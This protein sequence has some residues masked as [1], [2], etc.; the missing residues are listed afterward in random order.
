MKKSAASCKG[1]GI[2]ASEQRLAFRTPVI[3]N[4]GER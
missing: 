3:L 1:G 4:G 2:P